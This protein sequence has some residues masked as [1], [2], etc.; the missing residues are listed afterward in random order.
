MNYSPPVSDQT[1]A[2]AARVAE[3]CRNLRQVRLP[4]IKV[5]RPRRAIG[6]PGGN[7]GG[8]FAAEGGVFS[9]LPRV[10]GDGGTP[11]AKLSAPFGKLPAPLAKLSAPIG[12]LPAPIR[13]NSAP[14]GKNSAP[15][16]ATDGEFQSIFAPS[17]LLAA[18][19]G[20]KLRALRYLYKGEDF[21]NW[22]PWPHFTLAAV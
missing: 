14:F 12:K 16:G 3:L 10:P 2:P 1:V 19:S 8:K 9:D 6:E 22:S 18:P 21:G 5:R 7:G 20:R 11:L 4:V 13:K 15:R 17:G